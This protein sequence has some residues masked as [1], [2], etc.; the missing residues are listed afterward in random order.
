MAGTAGCTNT[1]NIGGGP[2]EPDV[3][4]ELAAAVP[5]TRIPDREAPFEAAEKEPDR[6]RTLTGIRLPRRSVGH[7]PGG[8][9]ELGPDGVVPELGHDEVAS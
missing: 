6:F 4:A 3:A 1:R 7:D 2:F 8:S 9:T 5:A